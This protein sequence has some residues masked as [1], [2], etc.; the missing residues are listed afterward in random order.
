MNIIG[1]DF[2]LRYPGVCIYT[3][4]NKFHFIGIVNTK[5]THKDTRVHE[6]ANT[7]QDINIISTKHKMLYNKDS[8]YFFKERNKL[9]NYMNVVDTLIASI[10][11]YLEDS[12][13]T[14]EGLSF[15]AQGNSKFDLAEAVGY[16]KS[17]LISK[18]GIYRLFIFSP[19]E[20]KNQIGAKGNASKA[21]IYSQ[22][23]E[24]PQNQQVKKSGFYSLIQSGK[25]YKGNKQPKIISP[26]ED[27]IDAYLCTLK[28][29]NTVNFNQNNSY[30]KK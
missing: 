9:Y 3:S 27:M 8:D 30:Q 7:Y 10:N 17:R 21:T 22:F 18:I 11:D 23:A 16:L 29:I 2:S 20:L 14:L 1:I 15:N 4:S 19:S 13:V 26:Y 6:E 28:V 24:D 25:L 5:S 12:I